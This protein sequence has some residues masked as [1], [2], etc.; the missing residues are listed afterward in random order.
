VVLVASFMDLTDMT[1]VNVALPSLRRD[2]GVGYAAVQWITA[3]YSLAFGLLL[4]AGGRLGDTFGRRRVFLAGMAGF[5][6][7]S[8]LCGCASDAT[9]LIWARVFQGAMAALMVPQVLAIIHVTFPAHERGRVYAGYGAMVGLAGVCGPPLGGLLVAGD[10]CGLGWRPIFLVN[11]PVGTAGLLLGRRWLRESR[12]PDGPRLDLIG[13][14]LA[15]AGL[16]ALLYPLIHGRELGWPWWCFASMAA[17]IPVLAGFLRYERRIA[18]RGGSPLVVLAL[19]R[20][21][22][23]AAGLAVQLLLSMTAGMLFLSWALYTQAGLGWT[24]LRA[25]LAGIPLAVGVATA[26]GLSIQFLVP[27]FGRKVLQAGTVGMSVG[28]AAMIWEIDR[29][30]AGVGP[31]QLAAPLLVFGIGLGL[32]IA[33]L[34][35]IV[36]TDVPR[37]DA[38]SASGLTGTNVQL[39]SAIG[40]AL[41]TLALLGPMGRGSAMDTQ[42]FST[43][44]QR[45]LVWVI[46]F[47]AAMFALM[48]A[49]PKNTRDGDGARSAQP[50]VTWASAREDRLYSE[51]GRRLGQ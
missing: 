31:R 28:A 51:H 27:R 48:F 34:G 29:Y 35:D 41:V 5:T 46:G 40:S 37:A 10:L 15:C 7:A 30:A 43:A 38:G 11:L 22:T 1:I 16:L 13:T 44:F 47:M 12:S 36:L 17:A 39:G 4:I 32:V 18:G 23:F 8:T 3:G 42:A 21:R 2:L 9:V 45:I 50:R 24:P 33:P 19:F 26:A 49:L 25:G 6:A 14:A 20:A